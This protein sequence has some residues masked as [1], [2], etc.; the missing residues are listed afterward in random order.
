MD[1]RRRFLGIK[2][3][4]QEVVTTGY[5][6]VELN[7]QWRLNGDI[8]N[9]DSSSYDGVYESFSNYNVSNSC[10]TLT[11]RIVDIE[12]FTIYIRSNSE[13]YYDYVMVSQLDKTINQNTSYLYNEL[14]KAHT[15]VS[16]SS[17]TDIYSYTPVVFDN[18]GGGEHTINVVYIK[19]SSGNSGSDKG[20]VLIDK[21]FKSIDSP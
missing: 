19:D 12:S 5:Y 17:Q 20:Y 3:K 16:Q 9:P 8:I 18:I 15:R 6:T 21:N 7:D 11:I 13:A 2:K 14:V 1:S 4:Q 10:A